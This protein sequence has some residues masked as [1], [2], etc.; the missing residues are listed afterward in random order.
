VSSSGPKNT[1]L[2]LLSTP[3]TANYALLNPRD[4]P[5]APVVSAITATPL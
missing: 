1:A 3:V 5:G 4:K 2:W